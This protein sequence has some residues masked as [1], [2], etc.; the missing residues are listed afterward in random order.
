MDEV[1][2]M[3]KGYLGFNNKEDDKDSPHNGM[4]IDLEFQEEGGLAASGM[5]PELPYTLAAEPI[6]CTLFAISLFMTHKCFVKDLGP[7]TADSIHAALLSHY[8]HL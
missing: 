2:D 3:N 5:P 4:D 7:S 1:W 8:N 6:K